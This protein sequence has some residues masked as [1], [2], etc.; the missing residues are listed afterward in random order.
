MSRQASLRG[1][2][3]A[4]KYLACFHLTAALLLAV[5]SQSNN[6]QPEL[7]PVSFLFSF[8]LFTFYRC[9]ASHRIFSPLNHLQ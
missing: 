2:T 7:V 5:S 6:P 9:T 4:L 3:V 1:L 8:R